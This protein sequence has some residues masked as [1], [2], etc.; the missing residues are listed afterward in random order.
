MGCPVACENASPCLISLVSTVL[1][2]SS[3][4]GDVGH[5]VPQSNPDQRFLYSVEY[6]FVVELGAHGFSDKENEARRSH[7][8][9]LEVD[10][11]SAGTSLLGTCRAVILYI[12]LPIGI[13]L[14]LTSAIIPNCWTYCVC[15]LPER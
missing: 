1:A 12:W 4:R 15:W 5:P 7:R 8:T 14:R 2:L 6:S 10:R 13:R 11:W 9:G 3:L